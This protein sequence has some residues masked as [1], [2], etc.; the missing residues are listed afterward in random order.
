M[1]AELSSSETIGDALSAGT[2]R[3]E[4]AGVT[5]ARHD[6]E[7]L[8]AHLLGTD[9]GGLF[10]R[11]GDTLDGR[12]SRRYSG[13]IRRRADREP[14]QHVL[15]VQEFYGLSLLTDGR[16]LVPRPE[17]EGLV[18]AA[19]GLVPASGARVVDLGTG[20]GCIVV[21]LAVERPDLR[22]QALDRSPTALALARE[23]AARHDVGARIEFVERDIACP[24]DSWRGTMDLV[25]SN[26]PYVSEADWRTLEP[27]VR[28]HDPCEALVAGPTGLEAYRALAPASFSL[29][30]PAGHLVLELGDRQAESVRAIVAG[31]GFDIL[32][33]RPDL[34]G[35]PRVLVAV[36]PPSGSRS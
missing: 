32:E 22:I 1:L 16:A 29:L 27:E 23:N 9:R 14:L 5:A 36:K 8:L 31:E 19:L 21:A 30:R 7:R 20:S 6:A 18:Q 34:R 24:P 13:W 28:E 33:V 2:A 15:E 10:L 12:M 11:R 35:I 4:R 17:T 26:P 25:V 3:L